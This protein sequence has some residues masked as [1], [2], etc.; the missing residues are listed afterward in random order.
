MFTL[1]WWLVN[2]ESEKVLSYL[3]FKKKK[4]IALLSY[5]WDTSGKTKVIPFGICF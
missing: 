2:P 3:S 4:K 1:C 5:Y